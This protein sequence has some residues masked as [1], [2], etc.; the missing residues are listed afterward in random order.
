MDR[1]TL[2][3]SRFAPGFREYQDKG[4]RVLTLLDD[5]RRVLWSVKWDVY[6]R[7]RFPEGI[8]ELRL[9]RKMRSRP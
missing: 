9:E 8:Y 2:Y 3:A 5:Q 4:H 7:K 6:D 1:I